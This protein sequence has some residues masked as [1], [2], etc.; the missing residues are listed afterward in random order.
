MELSKNQMEYRGYIGEFSYDENMGLFEGRLINIEDLI[1]FHGK[2]M[3]S[4]LSDFQY[5]VEDYI[6]LCNE[7]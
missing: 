5:A 4:L 6:E 7:P 1:L 2:S 3:G